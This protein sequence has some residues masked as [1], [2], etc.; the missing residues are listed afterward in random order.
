MDD[1]VTSRVKIAGLGHALEWTAWGALI[2]GAPLIISAAGY[3]SFFLPK[4]Q[5]IKWIAIALL[6][7]AVAGMAWG[8]AF[9]LPLRRQSILLML[10]AA[11][12]ALSII[13]AESRSLAIDG[14]IWWGHLLLIYFLFLN[15]AGER[16][17]RVVGTAW[18]LMAGA[19]I[20]AA[21]TLAQDYQRA[22]AP[23]DLNVMSRLG[24]WR[25]YL[26]AGLGNTNHIGDL[27]ALGVIAGMG[28]WMTGRGG[29]RRW[30]IA[31]MMSVMLAGLVVVWSVGSNLGLILGGGMFLVLYFKRENGRAARRALKRLALLALFAFAAALFFILPHPANP[32]PPGIIK[33]AFSSERWKAGGPTRLAIWHTTMETIRERLLLGAGAGNFTYVYPQ[34]VTSA[35]QED[36]EL[37]PYSGSWTNAAHNIFM[38]AWC[39]TGLVGLAL[40]LLI[41]FQF[42]RK[43]GR[44]L[45][46]ATPV[47]FAARL[48][49]LALMTAFLMHAMMNFQLQ[50]PFGAVVFMLLLAAGA[51]YREGFG[52]TDGAP[53]DLILPIDI[54]LAGGARLTAWLRNMKT[55]IR[56]AVALDWSRAGAMTLSAICGAA[57]LAAI[58]LYKPPVV[59]DQLYKFSREEIAM[60]RAAEGEATLK[61]ALDVWPHH[62][63][64][65]SF[66]SAWLLRS[67]RN[68]DA[69]EQLE[70]VRGR[71]SALEIDARRGVALWQLGQREAAAGLWARYLDV[72]PI[73]PAGTP[74]EDQARAFEQ[75]AKM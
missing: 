34:T 59:S 40:L 73:M 29:W 25:G 22:F 64:A 10:F 37:A 58:W 41:V 42:Y 63:D 74:L 33:E 16:R 60:G 52:G 31:A 71:L 44:G 57:A 13:W 3:D 66:Y 68:A 69:L 27:L 70:L 36:P 56:L 20:T 61:E 15:F 28:F 55:P 2:L 12:Q 17:S 48:T 11:W 9:T 53:R 51:G 32:H 72:R 30:T 23:G 38:Q 21:W 7:I 4:F 1:S 46:H 24:D 75:I 18:L 47:D 35:V 6:M 19:A 43:V 65:R 8:R 39:E 62:S 5:F 14:A 67:G 50:T 26:A 45:F 49:L 54:P